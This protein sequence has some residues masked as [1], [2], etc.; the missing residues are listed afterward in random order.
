[1]EVLFGDAV[2]AAKMAFGVAPEILDITD[3]AFIFREAF[4]VVDLQIV[5]ACSV[6]HFVRAQGVGLDNAAGRDFV[7]QDL[8][9]AAAL[10]IGKTLT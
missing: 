2:E 8:L 10:Y 1:M 4:G 9:E 3:V 5:Q 7:L 6:E